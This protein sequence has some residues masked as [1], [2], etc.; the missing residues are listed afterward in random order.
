MYLPEHFKSEDWNQMVALIEGFS[1]GLLISSV[2]NNLEISH[3]PFRVISRKPLI[4]EGH[5]AV[6]NPVSKQV[7]AGE[8]FTAV[9]SAEHAYI[10]PTWYHTP[11]LVPTWNY[12]AVHVAGEVKPVS[13]KPSLA[14]LV[15]ELADQ[16][17]RARKDPWIPDYSDE[18]L[19]Q[20]VGFRMHI[21]R[22][23]GKFKLSQ[24]RSKKD[25]EGLIRGLEKGS[26]ADIALAKRMRESI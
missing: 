7:F 9:F 10:S 3:I 18:M 6:A 22:I 23:D 1:F 16:F 5:V 12:V 13:D 15:E 21:D 4:L 2:E 20:I 19:T 14:L 25:R 17:E 8:R 24:N 11:G 26:A